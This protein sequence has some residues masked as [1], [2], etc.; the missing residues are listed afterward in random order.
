MWNSQYVALDADIKNFNAKSKSQLVDAKSLSQHVHAK[1]FNA[2]LLSQHA[3]ANKNLAAVDQAD[4]KVA[5][6]DHLLTLDASNKE[7]KRTTDGTQEAHTAQAAAVDTPMTDHA[8]DP[9]V[10]V[11]SGEVKINASPSRTTAHKS[12]HATL[13]N[14]IDTAPFA[15]SLS[16]SANANRRKF[17]SVVISQLPNANATRNKLSTSNLA[18]AKKSWTAISTLR[19]HS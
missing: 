5:S 1:N 4:V 3:D 2:K 6:I 17:A 8:E 10:L 16:V 12:A 9:T 18:D 14:R 13:A 11:E 7:P 15:R 19:N